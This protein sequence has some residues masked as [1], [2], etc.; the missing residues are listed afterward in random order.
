MILMLKDII[1]GI[2]LVKNEQLLQQV[3]RMV[4]I[5]LPSE[6]G[7]TVAI[8]QESISNFPPKKYF[9]IFSITHIVHKHV[10]NVMSLKY[11]SLMLTNVPT[12]L[13][14]PSNLIG[15]LTAL[16]RNFQQCFKKGKPVDVSKLSEKNKVLY[17]LFHRPALNYTP[18]RAFL[19]RSRENY[20]YGQAILIFKE[21]EDAK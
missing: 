2:Y 16:F 13:Y 20:F 19:H 14:S 18:I 5:L 4:C 6:E 17:K 10:N 11:R 7:K 12:V 9:K 1:P 15:Y 8:F 3:L 21:E